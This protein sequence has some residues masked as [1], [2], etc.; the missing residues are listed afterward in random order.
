MC[1]DNTCD[2]VAEDEEGDQKGFKKYE[3]S[4]GNPRTMSEGEK[5]YTAYEVQVKTN[6]HCFSLKD[7][8]IRRRYSEFVWLSDTL[9]RQHPKITHPALPSKSWLLRDHFCKSFL[10]NRSVG[11]QEYLDK[12]VH[13]PMFLSSR[14]LHLFLQ[15]NLSTKEIEENL[16]GQRDDDVVEIGVDVTS[17]WAELDEDCVFMTYIEQLHDDVFTET[18]LPQ[19]EKLSTSDQ[20]KGRTGDKS[21]VKLITPPKVVVPELTVTPSTPVTILGQ[22]TAI[23]KPRNNKITVDTEEYDVIEADCPLHDS[24][25]VLLH[26]HHVIPPHSSAHDVADSAIES[27][28]N[29]SYEGSDHHFHEVMAKLKSR[30]QAMANK[31]VVNSKDRIRS[32]GGYRTNGG[33]DNNNPSRRKNVSFSK[34]VIVVTIDHDSIR[35]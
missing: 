11:L 34:D 20:V 13:V 6:R 7:S 1:P 2:C 32:P 35:S 24:L 9:K 27:S 28:C 17:D 29:S 22:E 25:E 4:V 14:A 3:V 10:E 15:S 5:C 31:S 33:G 12:L 23:E 16:N 18:E 21:P 30:S 26:P 19:E 8:T